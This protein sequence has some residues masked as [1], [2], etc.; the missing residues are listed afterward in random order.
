MNFFPEFEIDIICFVHKSWF[1][2]FVRR[3]K[4]LLKLE[5]KKK[6]KKLRP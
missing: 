6:K 5:K 4:S 2:F 1:K 3:Q